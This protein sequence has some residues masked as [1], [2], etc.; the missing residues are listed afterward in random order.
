M[1]ASRIAA[2]LGKDLSELRRSPGIFL[3]GVLTGLAS[4]IYPFVIAVIVPAVA[5]ERLSDSSDFDIAIEMYRSQPGA[6]ALSAEGAIQAAIFQWALTLIVGLTTVTGSMSIA[7]HSVIGEKQSRALEPL[8][9]TPLTTFELLAAKVV[10]AA[11][12]GVAL[13]VACFSLYVVLIAAFAEPGVWL[14][15]LT[16]RS[17]VFVFV[18][19]PLAALLGLQLAVCASARTNDARSAQ[20]TGAIL[21]VIPIAALQIAQFLGGIVLTSGMMLLIAAG[22][23]GLNAIM[24]RIAIGVF[25]RE[26]ILTRWK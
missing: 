23:V 4:V 11:V 2:L 12:P 15:M 16:V 13:T 24:M 18:L 8:L 9:S 25:D 22:F 19:G 17:L 7:A 1:T 3:P 26:S 5:G 21:I 6:V 14:S 20:Q 10:G